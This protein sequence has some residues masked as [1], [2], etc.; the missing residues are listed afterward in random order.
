MKFTLVLAGLSAMTVMAATIQQRQNDLPPCID[1]EGTVEGLW[2]DRTWFL[3]YFSFRPYN[4][5]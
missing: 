2:Q 3:N 1:G 4:F 5:G